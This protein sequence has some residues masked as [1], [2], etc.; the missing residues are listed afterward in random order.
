MFTRKYK[1]LLVI[2]VVF[3]AIFFFISKNIGNQNLILIKN[4]IPQE[5]KQ[6]LKKTLF[7][8]PTLKNENQRLNEYIKKIHKEKIRTATYFAETWLKKNKEKS[9]II[10][11]TQYFNDTV[12]IPGVER[13]IEEI[14]TKN[15][16]YE[17]TRIYMP[18]PR[19]PGGGEVY[20]K[21]GAH[22]DIDRKN[23]ILALGASNFYFLSLAD[24][25]NPNIK[26]KEIKSNFTDL[27]TSE[28]WFENSQLTITDI[29]VDNDN[30]YIAYTDADK[31]NCTGL[32]ISKSKINYEFLNF[33]KFWSSPP[34][35]CSKANMGHAGGRIK[36]LNDKMIL[37]VGDIGTAENRKGKGFAAS[38]DEKD[39]KGKIIE[40]DM[41]DK[42][43]KFLTMGHRNPQ[44]LFIN[45]Q[46]KLLITTEHGPRGGDEVNI[47]KL[48]KKNNEIQ[49]FGW[50]VSSYGEHYDRKFR[51]WAPLHK[52]HSDYGFIEP[53][54]YYTP[55]I[56]ISEVI[57]VDNKF[58]SDF[59]NDFFVG[60]MGNNIL[61]FDMSIH[62]LRFDK[63]FKKIV[64]E[65]IIVL[66]DRV[67]DM[68]Q[69]KNEVLIYLEKAPSLGILKFKREITN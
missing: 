48:D 63:N 68:V 11:D 28:L 43:Y 19:Q 45:K 55:S 18:F 22:I 8:I 6:V 13:D 35:Q 53:I 15:S 23:L 17:L 57:K 41:N 49:N 44:G 61:E 12:A 52:S 65:D 10:L 9:E 46:P 21:A 26:I 25:K 29:L 7:I 4:L 16:V 14:I 54:K 20:N 47:V 39:F 38:L 27:I 51:E 33:E 31:Q 36:I 42:S 37:T 59:N 69:N 24:L 67:R 2:F 30:I 32:F 50:P 58:N 34:T 1:I 40:I 64:F 66:N 3:S 5:I 62:H 60:A 56:A